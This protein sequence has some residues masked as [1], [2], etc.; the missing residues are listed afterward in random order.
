MNK[1][2]NIPKQETFSV[3]E[4]YFENL[5]AKIQ[6]R[7]SSAKPEA[8]TSFIFRYKLQ[9]VLPAVFF[10]AFGV[11]W[12]TDTR[13]SADVASMLASIE[14]EDIVTYLNNTEITTE[15]LLEN[16]EFNEG[17]LEE[18]ENAVYELNMDDAEMD[19]VLNDID[20]ENI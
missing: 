12:F 7:V 6:A 4:G 1:L 20:L 15:D 5:P 13:Q 17:D 10:V 14:T 18:I 16:V 19:E 3:P 11:F 8:E 9:Y 2:E